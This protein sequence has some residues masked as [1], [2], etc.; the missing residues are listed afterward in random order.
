VFN[1]I[2]VIDFYFIES[3]RFAVGLFGNIDEQL[4]NSGWTE[5]ARKF[6]SAREAMGRPLRN[7]GHIRAMKKFV[8]FMTAQPFY[9]RRKAYL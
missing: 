4:A 9:E 3:S 8:D 6:R 5:T 7:I 1:N 2:T